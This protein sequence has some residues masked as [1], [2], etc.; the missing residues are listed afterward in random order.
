MIKNLET[1][2]VQKKIIDAARELFINKGFKGATIRDIASASGTNIAMVNYYFRSKDKLFEAIFEESF[3]RIISKI[4]AY[5]DADLPFFELIEKWVCSYYEVMKSNPQL[6]LF[7][8]SEFKKNPAM[9]EEKIR[10]KNPYRVF[11]RLATRI[12]D[13]IRK[14]TI[15]EIPLP[16]FL[17]SVFSLCIFPFFLSPVATIL[18]NLSQQQFEE[19]LDNQKKFVVEFIINAIKKE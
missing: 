15:R 16:N 8:I 10:M 18:L 3:G 19:T 1:T 9:L 5:V 12:N 13:E 7:I 11:A 17:I 4:F 6:P 14:G 2:D